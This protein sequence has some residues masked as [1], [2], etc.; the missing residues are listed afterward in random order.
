MIKGQ[1]DIIAAVLIIIIGIALTGTAYMW[2]YP[3]IEKRQG[4]AI[5]ERITNAF[6]RN[7]VN[8]LTNKIEFIAN[9]GGEDTFSIDTNGIWIL[10]EGDT[11]D[12]YNPDKNCILFS[13]RSKVSNIA[14]NIGWVPI[15][16][17]NTN[18]TGTAGID[19]P[20][21]IFARSDTSEGAYNI[22]YKL[23]FRQLNGTDN[24]YLILLKPRAGSSTVS[25]AKSLRIS[26]G[27]IYSTGNLIITEIEI[28]LG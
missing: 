20:S 27:K 3:L 4:S 25:T 28:L 26:R 6:N 23:W 21:V 22:T 5:V 24:N 15:S 12:M 13:F 16:S 2:G 18:P 17:P 10:K 7:N 14:P 1:G 19:D 9:N 11:S 8:S